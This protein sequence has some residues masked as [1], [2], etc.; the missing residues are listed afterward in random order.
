ML[1]YSLLLFVQYYYTFQQSNKN[2]I[3]N[4]KKIQLTNKVGRAK[5]VEIKVQKNIGSG[6]RRK[7]IF[8]IKGRRRVRRLTLS[9]DLV[10]KMTTSQKSNL[11]CSPPCKENLF[12]MLM[13]EEKEKKSTSKNSYL[14]FMRGTPSFHLESY[15]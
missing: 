3:M 9:E 13:F 5:H 14:V 4:N 8:L 6:E 1:H 11:F 12:K 15:F 10:Y 2:K 7:V